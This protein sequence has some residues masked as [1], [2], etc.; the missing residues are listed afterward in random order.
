DGTELLFLGQCST[1]HTGQLAVQTE[2]VLEGDGCQSLGLVLN[3]YAFLCLDGLMQTLVIAAAEHQ[4]AGE[5]VDNDDLTVTDNVVDIALHDTTSLDGLVD[6]VH[7]GGVLGIGQV[8]DVEVLLCA[9]LALRGQGCG[10]CLLIDDVVCIDIVLLFLCVNF[11]D[12]QS[13]QG[14]CE[15]V[16]QL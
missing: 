7:E 8:V 15:T 9:L 1:G 4:T 11:L 12:A 5:L 3:L 13:G 10:A 6:V 2:E 16:S 14:L